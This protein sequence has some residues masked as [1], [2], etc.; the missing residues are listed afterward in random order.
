MSSLAAVAADIS[1]QRAHHGAADAEA[2]HHRRRERTG[3]AVEEDADGGDTEL[4]SMSS[5]TPAAMA[6]Q[7]ARRGAQAGGGEQ[8]DEDHRDDDEG[9]VLAERT[10]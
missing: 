7:H 6:D 9:V 3:K 1:K 10:L 2:V 4:T 5:R 8:R